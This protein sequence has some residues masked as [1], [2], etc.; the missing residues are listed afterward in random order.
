MKKLS[1]MFAALATAVAFSSCETSRDDNP[2]LSTHEGEPVVN[3]LNDP[4]MQDQYIEFTTENEAGMLQLTCS[5]P[6][7]YGYAA[8]ARYKVQVSMTEDF[9]E[10]R[11][12][13]T[14]YPD[15]SEI[16]PVNKNLAE[17][18]CELLQVKELTDLP[19]GY[20]PMYV[21]L[22]ADIYTELGEVVPNTTYLSNVVAFKHV[23]VNYL[24]AWVADV[25][26]DLYLIG[27]MNGWAADDAYK[28]YTGTE[29]NTWVTRK[30]TIPA[31]ESFKVSPAT[32]ND[33]FN[34][35]AFNAGLN[36]VGITVGQPYTLYVSQDSSDIPLSENFS[37]IAQL[38]YKGGAYILTL[39]PD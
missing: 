1:I 22:R 18:I 5:Q 33:K 16:T 11:E 3:F 32:W 19:E 30:I 14:A 29:K 9:A 17:A 34:G 36:Q 23:R 12:L 10:F 13:N 24:A 28:F 8:S 27:T 25:P 37:G 39:I 31:G 7:E 2:V 4:V 35:E 26:Q 38:E 15:C 6:E 20:Y 21:R